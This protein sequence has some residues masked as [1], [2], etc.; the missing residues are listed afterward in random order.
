[1]TPPATPEDTDT[2]P[3]AAST[4]AAETPE[5]APAVDAPVPSTP[6]AGTATKQPDDDDAPLLT[7]QGSDSNASAVPL[8][9]TSIMLLR[10][11]GL[12]DTEEDDVTPLEQITGEVRIDKDP[13]LTITADATGGDV[14]PIDV[15]ELTRWPGSGA[16]AFRYFRQP[17]DE[18]ITVQ[19]TQARY[20]V[21]EVIPTVVSRGLVEMMLDEEPTVTYRCRFLI[22]STERQRLRVELPTGMQLLSMTI[23]GNEVRPEPDPTGGSGG[24]WDPYF[25]RVRRTGDSD[26]PFIL[27]MQFLRNVKRSPFKEEGYLRGRVDMP[28]PR[29]VSGELR[30]PIQQLQVVAWVPQEYALVGDPSGFEQQGSTSLLMS[31]LGGPTRVFPPEDLNRWIGSDA[32]GLLDFPTAGRHAYRYSNL[33]GSNV[34]KLLWWDRIKVTVLLSLALALIAWLLL[35]TTWENKLGMLLFLAFAGTVIGLLSSMHA[36]GEGLSA[37][38]YGL[39]FLLGLW[40]IHGLLGRRTVAHDGPS[41]AA[42]EVTSATPPYVAV[43]PPPGLFESRRESSGPEDET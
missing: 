13:S 9:D 43:V 15:R 3:P 20:D 23:D 11:L 40:L 17:A 41:Q 27:A 34:I 28:L 7:S 26:E 1:M 42:P 30:A 12:A 33:G 10:P 6:R 5:A 29:I 25:V 19:I 32:S 36:L 39:A 2:A 22:R 31:L 8:Y 38:R 35:G 14:E 37:A 16:R 18:A 21:Q 24:L 4:S